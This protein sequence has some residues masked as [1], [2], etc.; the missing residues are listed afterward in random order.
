[1]DIGVHPKP[2]MVMPGE[3]L[4]D[5]FVKVGQSGCDEFLYDTYRVEKVIKKSPVRRK[6]S[7]KSVLS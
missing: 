1:M 3:H 2:E 4:Y 6:R 5:D 7:K